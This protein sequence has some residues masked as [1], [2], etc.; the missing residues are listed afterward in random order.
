MKSLRW[1]VLVFCIGLFL[2]GCKDDRDALSAGDLAKDF[3]LDALS[4]DR[5]YL[6]QHVEKVVVLTF[7][8]TWCRFCKSQ[9]VELKSFADLPG[10][11]SLIIA[12]VCADP[13]NIEDVK[14]V[15]KE[16]GIEYPVLLDRGAQVSK[17]YQISQ[18]PTTVVIDKGRKIALLRQG[19][20]PV[21]MQ[22]IKASVVSLLAGDARG[23]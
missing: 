20:S 12:A 21:I 17:K 4:R 23:G 9:M 13:E 14:T 1:I 10:A 8:T 3:R 18:F 2:A 5:F 15:V 11:D 7:W 22:Q 6:N 19:Y 16:L